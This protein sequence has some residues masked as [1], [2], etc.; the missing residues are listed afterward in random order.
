[1]T[2]NKTMLCC[3]NPDESSWTMTLL[4]RQGLMELRL[5]I[6]YAAKGNSELLVFLTSQEL[7]LVT[8]FL[9]P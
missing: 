8:G 1:M 2:K 3:D 4:P 5:K 7:G 6:P 9:I